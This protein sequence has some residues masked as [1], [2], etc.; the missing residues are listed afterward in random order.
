MECKGVQGLWTQTAVTDENG[1]C[2]FE[3]SHP[4]GLLSR[5]N[6]GF[7]IFIRH[8]GYLPRTYKIFSENMLRR[9]ETYTRTEAVDLRRYHF[10]I[11]CLSQDD[12]TVA[13][14]L[15]RVLAR[16]SVLSSGRLVDGGK[17]HAADMEQYA[18]EALGVVLLITPALL[19]STNPAERVAA[20]AGLRDPNG[21][22]YVLPVLVGPVAESSR[23]AVQAAALLP[24]VSIPGYDGKTP[25]KEETMTELLVALRKFAST[26]TR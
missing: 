2:R 15:E 25:L 24:V 11:G 26:T 7:E 21:R 9:K 12:L 6:P 18:W 5:V 23:A 4:Q 10:I 8:P 3:V 19:E 17:L 20:A 16:E 22:P 1:R 14:P 13:G